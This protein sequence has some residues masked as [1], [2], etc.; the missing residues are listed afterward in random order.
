MMPEENRPGD[1]WPDGRPV[2]PWADPWHDVIGDVRAAASQP[3][4]RTLEHADWA[5]AMRLALLPPGDP[6]HRCVQGLC[7][8]HAG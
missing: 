4:Y 2:T 8:D 7:D 5:E 3:D 6:R 1:R